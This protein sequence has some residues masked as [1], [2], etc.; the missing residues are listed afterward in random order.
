VVAG[1]V[2]FILVLAAG[3]A[4]AKI[5]W[6]RWKETGMSEEQMRGGRRGVKPGQNDW[7]IE[8]QLMELLCKAL[9]TQERIVALLCRCEGAGG[10][11]RMNTAIN[12]ILEQR[13]TAMRNDPIKLLPTEKVLLS[14]TPIKDGADDTSV[15]ISWSSSDPSVGI[16]EQEDGRSAY[17]TTPLDAGSGEITA[18]APGYEDEIFPVSYA[19]P[20]PGKLNV[21][22]GVPVSDAP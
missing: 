21:T 8:Q 4:L 14:S 6:P 13:S 12:I 10:K 20:V 16:E 5:R 17:V 9:E 7:R 11:R 1:F 22:V 15:D 3:Y 18:S 2:A 19:A